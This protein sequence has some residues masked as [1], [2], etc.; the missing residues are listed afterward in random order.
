MAAATV[1]S[2]IAWYFC[3]RR[4]TGDVHFSVLFQI[5]LS[6]SERRRFYKNNSRLAK[7]CQFFRV[8]TCVYGVIMII[9]SVIACGVLIIITN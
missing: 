4:R 1:I 9:I 3:K 8:F 7:K 6:E 5:S 2:L